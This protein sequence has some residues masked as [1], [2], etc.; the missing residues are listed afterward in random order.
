MD[1]I[2]AAASLAAMSASLL[3]YLP[4]L[5]ESKAEPR[6]CPE[7]TELAPEGAPGATPTDQPRAAQSGA[8]EG[9]YGA[10]SAFVTSTHSAEPKFQ[11]K[12]W[13]LLSS[14]QHETPLLSRK[15]E[16]KY[17]TCFPTLFFYF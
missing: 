10:R 2:L 9:T 15:S 1:S 16:I 17:T 4:S 13:L 11:N 14:V 5:I 7:P 6:V 12:L 3:G 8:P